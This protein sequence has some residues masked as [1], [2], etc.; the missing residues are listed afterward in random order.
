MEYFNIKFISFHLFWKPV[1]QLVEFYF[2]NTPKWAGGFG[3]LPLIDVC[4]TI[5]GIPTHILVVSAQEICQERLAT[6]INGY[7]TL[8]L[9]LVF[10]LAMREFVPLLRH[11]IPAYY[12]RLDKL[13]KEQSNKE[14]YQR[15]S[16]K[17]LA[18]IKYHNDLEAF[19]KTVIINLNSDVSN[20][21][22][23]CLMLNAYQSLDENTKIRL[24][25]MNNAL[26]L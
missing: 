2:L 12:S 23:L 25:C 17:R 8:L 26:S 3:G 15:A 5:T 7:T 13:K 1:F 20:A 21:D 18:T 9:T 10:V 4:S 11:T 6:F 14:R 22:K 16:E 19:S 24:G